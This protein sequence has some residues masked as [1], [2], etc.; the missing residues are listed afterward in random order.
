MI[1]CKNWFSWTMEEEYYFNLATNSN[2]AQGCSSSLLVE[3]DEWWLCIWVSEPHTEEITLLLALNKDE[4]MDTID[5][6]AT[7]TVIIRAICTS[8]PH[9]PS[10]FSKLEFTNS[11]SKTIHSLWRQLQVHLDKFVHHDKCR[12][13]SMNVNIVCVSQICKLETEWIFEEL[14]TKHFHLL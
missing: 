9:S 14:E 11:F 6:L 7:S 5:L 3:F 13:V 10:T 2:I 1:L 8:G 12:I 4:R